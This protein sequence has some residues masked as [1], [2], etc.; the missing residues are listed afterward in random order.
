MSGQEMVRAHIFIRG[1]VQGVG[2]RWWM[3]RTARRI[4]VKGWVRN[5]PDGRV[6]A[7]LEGPRDRVVELIKL[8]RRG[9]SS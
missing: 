4:G 6:E 7:V 3:Q 5:L 1:F 8:A 2:F 9:P